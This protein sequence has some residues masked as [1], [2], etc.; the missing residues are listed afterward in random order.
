M[1]TI[2]FEQFNEELSR[3]VARFEKGFQAFTAPD[4]SEARLRQDFLDSFFRALGWDLEN[5]LGLVQ[6]RRE[7]EIE[8][9]TDVA[10]R[11]KRADY[12]FRV[13]NRDRF[14]CE[15]KKPR[16]VLGERYAFQAKRY[17]WNKS[18]PLA[19]LTDFEDLII[20]IVG[21]K[22]RPDSPDDGLW[23]SWNF[24]QYPLCARELWDLLSRERVAAGSIEAL[25]DSLP[26]AKPAKGKA[27]QQWLIHPERTKALDQDFLEYLDEERRSLASDLL[28]NNPREAML[29]DGQINEA[30]QRILDRLLF[31]RICE[32]RDI[33]TGCRLAKIVETWRRAYGHEDQRRLKQAHLFR[34]EAG[35]YQGRAPRESLWWAV[36]S[37]LRALDRRPPGNMP[38]FNGNL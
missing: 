3:L 10:G 17:A 32:D 30:A 23:K 19:V 27:R 35:T 25:L 24:R 36:V 38:F 22:P 33:D 21:G 29:V 11:A 1:N 37:H 8:S 31:L 28:A 14:V 4:Y 12:L 26:R 6:S 20:Y 7:V 34:E 5:K 2:T 15:A 13:E 18:L 9:R 16:E